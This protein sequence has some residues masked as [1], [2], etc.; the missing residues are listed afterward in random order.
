MQLKQLKKLLLG[1]GLLVGKL[2]S[3][4]KPLLASCSVASFR[5]VGGWLL[6]RRSRC[7]PK[8]VGHLHTR[9]YTPASRRA[10]GLKALLVVAPVA[11]QRTCNNK[12]IRDAV[13]ATR[14]SS[15]TVV[16]IAIQIFAAPES[17][18]GVPCIPLSSCTCEPLASCTW[19]LLTGLNCM[20][21][22]FR[23]SKLPSCGV[24]TPKGW[25]QQFNR[26][27][28]YLLCCS[29]RAGLSVSVAETPLLTLLRLADRPAWGK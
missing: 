14:G 10:G 3:S 5:R 26:R 4:A 28:T 22:P 16:K 27:P 21:G 17:S 20:P 29:M 2:A 25:P 12:V 18:G 1:A 9:V 8:S 6:S 15:L 23:W 11:L 7:A 19:V 13:H 24:S